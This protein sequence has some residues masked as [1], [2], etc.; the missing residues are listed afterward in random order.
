[1]RWPRQVAWFIGLWSAGVS[2]VA[3]AGLLIRAALSG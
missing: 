1:M 2:A 3:L